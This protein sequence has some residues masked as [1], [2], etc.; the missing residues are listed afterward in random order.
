M[1]KLTAAAIAATMAL[2]VAAPAAEAA[3]VRV[4]NI[5]VPAIDQCT[6]VGSK[7]NGEFDLDD[8]DKAQKIY[9]TPAKAREELERAKAGTGKSEFVDRMNFLA[10]LESSPV[11]TFEYEVVNAYRAC[12]NKQAYETDGITALSAD[13]DQTS[14]QATFWTLISV[15]IVSVIGAVALPALK[16]MLPANIAA[17]LP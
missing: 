1:K 12:A 6:I 13:M 15:G 3:Q 9:I 14:R 10:G 11:P 5:Y 7:Y 2:T 8:L 16:P 17:M 4:L